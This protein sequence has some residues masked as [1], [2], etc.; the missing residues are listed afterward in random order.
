[1]SQ[2]KK[3]SSSTRFKGL[4]IG[5]I[6]ITLMVFILLNVLAAF[7]A[8]NFTHF[9]K[10]DENYTPLNE[11]SSIPK[12]AKSILF[13]IKMPKP[14]NSNL[15]LDFIEVDTILG[16][17]NLEIWRFDMEPSKGVVALFHGYKATKSSLWNEA[18][19]F[20]RMGYTVILV[21]FRASGNSDGHQCTIGYYEAEDVSKTLVWSRK[22]YPNQKVFLYG[23][24]MGAASILR[25]V[26][27]LNA[28]PDGI[29]V[30]SSFATMLGTA[31]NRFDLMGVP[32][33]P[34]AQLLT[35]WG[36]YLNDFNALNHNPIEY[37]KNITCPTL[38]IHGMLDNRVSYEDSKNIFNNIQGPKEF[39]TFGKS[40]H[41]SILNKEEANWIYLVTNFMETHNH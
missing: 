34:S 35:F 28:K 21:D 27:E 29:L 8:W 15:D 7:Q 9:M 11:N 20:Y 13:G 23:I 3:N 5:F 30:Q 32:S 10:P 31:Q 19:A 25:S 1:M 18:L 26:G 16:D 4:F 37:A 2:V 6:S 40:G 24:S 38:V 36:G 22:N 17:L 14:K 41:E 12:K 33:F 39:A